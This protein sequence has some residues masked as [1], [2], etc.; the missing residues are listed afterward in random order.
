MRYFFFYEFF[1]EIKFN[2]KRRF[3]NF[4]QTMEFYKKYYRIILR[5]LAIFFFDF[6]NVNEILFNIFFL[7]L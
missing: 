3:K 2:F 4:G 1:C 6:I 7:Q 5:I